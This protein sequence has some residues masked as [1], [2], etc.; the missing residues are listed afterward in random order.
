MN[1]FSEGRGIREGGGGEEERRG[2][3]EGGGGE[4]ERRGGAIGTWG[5]STMGAADFTPYMPRLCMLKVPIASFEGSR[6][7]PSSSGGEN[8]NDGMGENG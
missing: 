2:I 1:T 6:A 7:L 8:G 5:V 3:R 4:E